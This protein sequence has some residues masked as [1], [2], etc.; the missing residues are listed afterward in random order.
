MIVFIAASTKVRA[1]G[2]ENAIADLNAV[3]AAQVSYQSTA[4]QFAGNLAQL[5]QAR[6]I[7]P[8]LATGDSSNYSFIL[9][10]TPTGYAVSAIPTSPDDTKL[11]TL[12]MDQTGLQRR[13]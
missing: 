4:G 5:G 7:P 6:L 1:P 13:F 9:S 3:Y 12:P 10:S 11:R 2:A 8:L